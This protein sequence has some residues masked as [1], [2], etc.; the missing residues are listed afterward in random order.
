MLQAP[1]ACDCD[2]FSSQFAEIER[3]KL[4]IENTPKI[5]GM[6]DAAVDS[7][8]AERKNEEE[9][10]EVNETVSEIDWM[11]FEDLAEGEAAIWICCVSLRR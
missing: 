1:S 10:E 11:E 7:F 6:W 3:V 9:N 8:F 5:Q 2:A 4:L